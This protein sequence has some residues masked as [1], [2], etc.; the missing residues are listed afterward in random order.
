MTVLSRA[1]YGP[2]RFARLGRTLWS[3]LVG[4]LLCTGPVTAVLALGW[5]SRSSGHAAQMRFGTVAEQPGW[6][7]GPREMQGRATGR[8]ARTLGGLAANVRAGL[9]TLTA[10]LVWTLPFTLLWLGAWWA[11]W[12]NS[13]NKGYEQAFV[14]PSVFL[15]GALIAAVVVPALPVMLAHLATEDRLAAA[16]EVRRLRSVIAQAGWRIPALAV[17]LV[18][19]AFPFTAAR[20]LTTTATDWA[21]WIEDLSPQALADLQGWISLSLAAMAFFTAWIARALAV[22]VYSRSAPRAAGLKPGLWDGSQA[23]EASEPGPAPSRLLAT[24]WYG[25]AMLITLPFVFLILAG[26]FLDHAWWRWIFHPALT[27]PWA[28]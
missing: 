13:F 12:E 16:F 4:T 20:G 18:V 15:L 2:G 22:R 10:L 17:L 27:L 23:A 11:G 25:L 9:M 8:F 24:L 19:L 21:P 14:G 26:Q 5:L 3:G 1:S 7:F 28:G 6:L